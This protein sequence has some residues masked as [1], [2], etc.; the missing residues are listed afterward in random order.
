MSTNSPQDK[1]GYFIDAESA[2]EMARLMHQDRLM[3]RSMDGPLSGLSDRANARYVLDLA[4]GPGGWVLDVAHAYP[5][6]QV[7]GVDISETMIQ[8]AKAQAK[9]R[10]LDNA[11]FQV[12]NILDLLDFPD[13]FF[14][15]VN[16][17]L[18]VGFMPGT[19]WPELL[20]ECFRVCRPGGIIRLTEADNWGVTTSDAYEKINSIAVQALRVAGHTFSPEEQKDSMGITPVL[21]RFLREAGCRNIQIRAHAIDYSVETEAHRG[22]YEN[23]RMSFS[24]LQPFFIKMGVTTEPD[25]EKL[26]Q[27]ALLEMMLDNF[28]AVWYFLTAQGQKPL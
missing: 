4:C 11:S 26:Y 14:D 2:S 25:I 27:Q 12:M 8:Y 17:R 5:E 18:I 13:N 7:V 21:G 23:F 22:W 28:N 10:H 15:V 1:E 6:T 9:V 3:T 24:L 19:A 16:A 20:R